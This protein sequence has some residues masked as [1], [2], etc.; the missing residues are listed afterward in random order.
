MGP[1]FLFCFLPLQSRILRINQARGL[2]TVSYLQKNGM[3]WALRL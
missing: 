2:I 1:N 3:L